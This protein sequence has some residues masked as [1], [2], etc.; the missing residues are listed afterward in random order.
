MW[1]LS[2]PPLPIGLPPPQC[3]REDSNLH[4][5]VSQTAPSAKLGYGGKIGMTGFEPAISCPP[6]KRLTKLGH[7]PVCRPRESNP[8]WIGFEPT[9]S[10][11]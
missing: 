8:H 3:H 11:N 5:T 6:D 1:I 9:A 10:A 7:I 4:W 2:L